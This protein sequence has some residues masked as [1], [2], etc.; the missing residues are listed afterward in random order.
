VNPSGPNLVLVVLDTARADLVGARSDSAFAQLGRRGRRFHHAVAPAPWTLPSH[1]SILSGLRPSVHGVTGAAVMTA[2]GPR[3][4][5][6]RIEALDGWMPELLRRRGFATFCASG[7]PWIGPATG[8]THGFET[9]FEAWRSAPLPKLA[10]PL[11]AAGGTNG[12]G[13]K[14][15]VYA[16]RALGIGDGG[17]AASLAVFRTFLD[18]RRG[19]SFFAFFNVMEPHAPYAP[20]RGHGGRHGPAALRTVRR[21]NADR[22]L[23]FCTGREEI[24]AEELALLRAQYRAEISYADAWLAGLFETLDTAHL[25]DDTVVAVTADHG[26]N[27]G[28]HHR[29]SHVLSMH[30]TL[31][32]V[33]L[34]IAGPGVEAGE[35]RAP[36]G[37][38]ALPGT[39][40]A[41][42]DGRWRDPTSA[43]GP[44]TAEYESAAAQVSGARRL[45]EQVPPE[46]REE[47][48]AR[49]VAAYE[50]PWKYA[51]S[52][53]GH[54]RLMDLRNDPAEARDVAAE[55]PEVLGRL[56][57]VRGT[58][59]GQEPADRHDEARL[60]AEITAHLEGLG[61]L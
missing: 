35:E 23:R 11:A 18:G 19:G 40:L 6:A 57:E 22:M 44:P 14:A 55:Q 7:N 27:L 47:L 59:S 9:V 41:A 12:I 21:W 8:L 38:T 5:R 30:E 25:R 10:D 51:A 29:L 15:A 36:T 2:A 56:R 50:G 32:H 54:E 39:L 43:D 46:L 1:A 37:L 33:P 13:R 17:A 53:D 52:S 31:L 20:P 61:Y 26:E 58:W 28:E 24:A 3:S 42:V 16:R 4:P 34:A 45:D 49:W 60:D 48:R